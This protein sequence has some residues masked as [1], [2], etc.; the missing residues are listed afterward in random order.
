MTEV[1]SRVWEDERVCL[2]SEINAVTLIHRGG[3]K[4]ET[5]L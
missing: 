1:S 3:H 5:V 4:N 2:G